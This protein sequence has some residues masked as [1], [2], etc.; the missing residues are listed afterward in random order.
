MQSAKADFVMSLAA[1]ST[2]GAKPPD[3]LIG[4]LN[5]PFNTGC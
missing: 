2:A 3:F 5:L 1:A 4:Q